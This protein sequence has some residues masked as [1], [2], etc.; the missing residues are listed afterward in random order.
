MKKILSVSMLIIIIAIFTTCKDDNSNITTSLNKEK[1]T[2]LAQKE[3]IEYPENGE[4][5]E[6]LLYFE[7]DS[8][9]T[10]QFYSLSANLPENASL[11][12]IMKN[13][14]WGYV[15]SSSINWNISGY[16]DSEKSQTFTSNQAGYNC[17]LKIIFYTDSLNQN[18]IV[19]EYYEF[20][21]TEPTKIKYIVTID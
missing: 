4:Y 7:K 2:D 12:I 17:D 16:N 18:N 14:N 10:E 20:N 19:I 15:G 6:N 11:K 9:N 21:S 3:L 1:S 13:G 8:F 5:G